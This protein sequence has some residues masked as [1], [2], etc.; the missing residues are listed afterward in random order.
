MEPVIESWEEVVPARSERP[1]AASP[2][3]PEFAA[4]QARRS[5]RERPGSEQATEET[6]AVAVGGF[7]WHR[8]D[9][10]DDWGFD[11]DPSDFSGAV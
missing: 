2:P 4:G 1:A 6:A 5:R 3:E 7:D 11:D 10:V 9:D 8:E